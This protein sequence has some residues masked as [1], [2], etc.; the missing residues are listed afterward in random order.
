MAETISGHFK[1]HFDESPISRGYLANSL[2]EIQL[3]R[4][5]GNQSIA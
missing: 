1:S 4:L 5:K 3:A 2:S